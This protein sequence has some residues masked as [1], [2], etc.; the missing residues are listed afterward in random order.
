M[1]VLCTSCQARFRV[2]DEKIGPRGAKVRCSQCKTVFAVQRE[3]GGT[4]PAAVPA[5]APRAPALDV[6]LE[7]PARSSAPASGDPFAFPPPPEPSFARPDTFAAPSFDPFAPAAPA[8]PEADPFA[9]TI[10]APAAREPHATEA[11]PFQAA[12]PFASSTASDDPFAAGAG[13]AAGAPEEEA[14]SFGADPWAATGSAALAEVADGPA[15][16]SGRA[17]GLPLTDLADLLGAAP[18]PAEP[19]PE[20]AGEA[21][22]PS[23]PDLTLEDRETPAAFRASGGG[24]DRSRGAFGGSE[25]AFGGPGLALDSEP[26]FAFGAPGLELSELSSHPEP[27]FAPAHHA[28]AALALATEPTPAPAPRA[29]L[30]PPPL[31]IPAHVPTTLDF[32]PVA[33]V[34]EPHAP[35]RAAPFTAPPASARR[36]SSARGARLTALAVN[37]VALVAVLAIALAMLVVWR[38]GRIEAAAFRPA[39][40]AAALR[41]GTPAGPFV[42]SDVRSGLYDRERAAPIL[43]VR[44]SIVSHAP[45]RV[46]SVRVAVEVVREGTVIARGEA[47][48]GAV[49]GPED[50]WRAA[51]PEALARASR[52]AARRAPD[53]IRPGDEVPFLVAIDEYPPQLAG[54]AL[55]IS[56]APEEARRR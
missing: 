15:E 44:G 35:V 54:A 3:H 39:A 23:G 55:R 12:D 46:R 45:A 8:G 43:F 21:A 26:A 48:A 37:A 29:P 36:G 17:R 33:E 56:A 30:R 47:L 1:I 27:S 51:T 7:P 18:A 20:P 34:P 10:P 14:S 13:D 5:P 22:P 9:W 53:E 31:P 2:A 50:L 28:S 32:I 25:P 11:D 38:G 6:E 24:R 4:P 41:H 49:P 16:S 19:P 40:I 52:A 42:A